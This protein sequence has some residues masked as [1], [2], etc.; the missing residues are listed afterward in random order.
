MLTTSVEMPTH[1]RV[2][3]DSCLPWGKR[4]QSLQCLTG[5][6]KIL[7]GDVHFPK[8][9]RITTH[10]PN[11]TVGQ[12]SPEGTWERGVVRGGLKGEMEQSQS[13]SL[14]SIRQK[15]GQSPS[16]LPLKSKLHTGATA[17]NAYTLCVSVLIGDSPPSVNFS[18]LI[19]L[20]ADIVSTLRPLV[21]EYPVGIT[22]SCPPSGYYAR[23]Y[24]TH[25]YIHILCSILQLDLKICILHFKKSFHSPNI[26]PRNIYWVLINACGVK[27]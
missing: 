5:T 13:L 27:K 2:G 23:F 8:W 12:G 18:W 21:L 10:T 7:K 14:E 16:S 22:F 19:S 20:W 15:D 11:M 17:G 9:A 1:L 24:I 3:T 25:I 6:C 4:S 26:E